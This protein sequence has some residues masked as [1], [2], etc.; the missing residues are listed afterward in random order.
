MARR[1]GFERVDLVNAIV[2]VTV[3]GAPE[4]RTVSRT[5]IRPVLASRWRA[6]LDNETGTATLAAPAVLREAEITV[7]LIPFTD[8]MPRIVIVPDRLTA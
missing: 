5:F 2:W 8:A 3:R 6:G 4:K 1:T 7:P